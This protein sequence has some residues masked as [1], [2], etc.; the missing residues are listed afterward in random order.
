MEVV[1]ST[2]IKANYFSIFVHLLHVSY[3]NNN[4]DLGFKINKIGI[5]VTKCITSSEYLTRWRIQ[6]VTFTW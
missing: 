5:V 3:K 6:C 4:V 1:R 2:T